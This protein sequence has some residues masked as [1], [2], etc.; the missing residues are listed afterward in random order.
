MSNDKDSKST[1]EDLGAK[2]RLMDVA[3]KLFAEKGLDGTSVRDIAKEA[4]LNLS[5]VS[6]YFGGKDGLYLELITSFAMNMKKQMEQIIAMFESEDINQES[7]QKILLAM[8]ESSSKIRQNHPHMGKIMQRERIAGLPFARE[9]YEKTFMPVGE[10]LIQQVTKAQKKGV[11]RKELNPLLIFIFLQESIIGFHNMMD[12]H[13][14]ITQTPL[15]KTK[16]FKDYQNQLVTIFI[17]GILA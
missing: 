13:L 5:L 2:A 14:N 16:N 7:V 11:I 12:C 8:V 3:A 10:A 9:I 6:Y 1:T 17:K 4:G 15:G